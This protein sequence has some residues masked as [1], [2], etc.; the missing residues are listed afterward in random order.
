MLVMLESNSLNMSIY[1]IMSL[2][3]SSE[4]HPL[5]SFT[6]TS[7]VIRHH[8]KCFPPFDRRDIVDRNVSATLFSI[9]AVPLLSD[10][11]V[12][13]G[14]GGMVLKFGRFDVCLVSNKL[15]FTLRHQ[16]SLAIYLED[17]VVLVEVVWVV[18][19]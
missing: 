15:C 2:K 4:T 11:Y 16:S 19:A 18:R 9:S 10:W 6:S 1:Y 12:A 14:D 17:A 8:L 13:S 5:T 7:F 3:S